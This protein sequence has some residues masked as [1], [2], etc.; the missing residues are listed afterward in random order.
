MHPTQ[1]STTERIGKMSSRSYTRRQYIG[2]ISATFAVTTIAASVAVA[3]FGFPAISYASDSSDSATT[4]SD[5]ANRAAAV[6]MTNQQKA[7]GLRKAAD[8]AAQAGDSESASTLRSW[9]TE[10]ES[11]DIPADTTTLSGLSVPS[12][13]ENAQAAT[14][15]YGFSTWATSAS[16]RSVAWLIRTT[17]G[18]FVALAEPLLDEEAEFAILNSSSEIANRIDVVADEVD[19]AGEVTSATVRSKIYIGLKDALGDGT[20]QVIAAAI[21]GLV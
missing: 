17:P 16:L 18:A 13:E 19:Q 2:R 14:Q 15:P 10:A 4:A 3:S 12:S 11:S 20:A 6:N 1:F 9:A 8:A 7:D 21:A 5:A